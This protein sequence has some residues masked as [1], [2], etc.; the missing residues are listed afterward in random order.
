MKFMSFCCL[1]FLRV[2]C[3]KFNFQAAKNI[4]ILEN[5]RLNLL[6]AIL[7]HEQ[8]VRVVNLGQRVKFYVGVPWCY[9]EVNIQNSEVWTIFLIYKITLITTH[10][11]KKVPKTSTDIYWNRFAGTEYRYRI[12][13]NI[14]IPCGPADSSSHKTA[15]TDGDYVMWFWA[16]NHKFQ[17][18]CCLPWLF[19]CIYSH[20][21]PV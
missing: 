18:V 3:W 7:G 19:C 9:W 12:G 15:L 14:P 4:Q 13:S 6:V 17:C 20:W 2:S 16:R 5:Y 21:Q 8:A 1:F 11:R 10:M